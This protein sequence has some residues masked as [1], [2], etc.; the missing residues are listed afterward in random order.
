MDSDHELDKTV[1]S[2]DDGSDFERDELNSKS[3]SKSSSK[4]HD[5][6][7]TRPKQKSYKKKVERTWTD[8]DI[9]SLIKEIEAQRTLWDFST[10]EY[11]MPKET[12]WEEVAAA[13][14]AQVNDCKAKWG[15]LRTTFNSNLAKYRKKKSGQSADDSFTVSW[16]FFK[17]MMFL[18]AS[19]V[20]Q[21]TQ[22]T[23]SMQLVTLLFAFE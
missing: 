1:V 21:S 18:E 2:N 23:S 10:P 6:K 12:V 14:S 17:A 11:K 13:V 8:A 15:N 5:A 22:S 19:K 20:S 16:K 7:K 3:K 4:D 9:F